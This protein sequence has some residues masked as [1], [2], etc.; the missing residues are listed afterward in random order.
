MVTLN[1]KDD[2]QHIYNSCFVQGF[3][4]KMSNNLY[5]DLQSYSFL[6]GDT[7]RRLWEEK[8]ANSSGA[9]SLFGLIVVFKLKKVI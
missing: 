9:I 1:K 3:E 7:K 2:C 4:W 6:L 8:R 5:A